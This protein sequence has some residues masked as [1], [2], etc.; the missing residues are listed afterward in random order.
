MIQALEQSLKN[1]RASVFSKNGRLLWRSETSRAL[2][3]D[4]DFPLSG[5]GEWLPDEEL[6]RVLAW[7]RS[8]DPII[9]YMVEVPRMGRALATSY[10]CP[11]GDYWLVFWVR[12]P[13]PDVLPSSPCVMLEEPE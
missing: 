11:F 2:V 1:E 9:S 13:L 7:L 4:A 10:K 8:D 3:T 6:R 12:T 5:W